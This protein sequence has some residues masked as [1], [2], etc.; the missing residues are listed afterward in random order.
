VQRELLLYEKSLKH[1]VQIA[2]SI[3]NAARVK[4]TSLQPVK[5]ATRVLQPPT[6]Q[7]STTICTSNS[8]I[9]EPRQKSSGAI[10]QNRRISGV[11]NWKGEQRQ[12]A[13]NV[14]ATSRYRVT[15]DF[16]KP[17]SRFFDMGIVCNQISRQVV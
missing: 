6:V 10:P 2:M 3:S 14:R 8:P 9:R 15:G 17:S 7:R 5:P 11:V 1:V 4:R 12:Y 16:Y 13:N